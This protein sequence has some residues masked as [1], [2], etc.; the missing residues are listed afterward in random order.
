MLKI[1]TVDFLQFPKITF[2]LQEPVSTIVPCTPFFYLILLRDL[3]KTQ[4]VI[5]MI[6]KF[7][8]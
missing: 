7:E 8:N 2:K 5:K 3:Q 4:K 6:I 1:L